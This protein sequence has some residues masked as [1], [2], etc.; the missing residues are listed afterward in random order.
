[1]NHIMCI[2]KF[3]SDRACCYVVIQGRLKYKFTRGIHMTEQLLLSE[4]TTSVTAFCT[5]L[6][7]TS[8]IDYFPIIMHPVVFYSMSCS[9]IQAVIIS[10]MFNIKI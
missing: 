8:L 1:M 7:H 10:Q 3:T 9:H 6:H 2:K 5:E 4:N